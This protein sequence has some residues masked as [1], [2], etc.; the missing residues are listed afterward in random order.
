M[1]FNIAKIIQ[2]EINSQISDESQILSLNEEDICLINK[3]FERVF[4]KKQ[5]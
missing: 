5:A 2:D 3:S 1:K 4:L